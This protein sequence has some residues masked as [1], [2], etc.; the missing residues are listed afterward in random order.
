M[1]PKFRVAMID[2]DYPSLDRA[3]QELETFEALLDAR[4]CSTIDEAIAFARHADGVIVQ[5]LGPVDAVFMDP[6]EKCKVIARTGI[7][8]DPIDVPA[9]TE[10]GICVVH[11][12]GYCE[13]EVAD[14]T[15]ALLLAC[16]RKVPL[17]DQN[18]K[19]GT[20][21]FNVGA[22][23]HRLR[24]RTLGLIGFGKIS[25]MVA[26][27]AQGFG[28][29]VVVHDPYLDERQVEEFDVELV[30]FD[31]LL[32]RSDFVSL[33]APLNDTSRGM[34]NSGAL[35]KM[36]SDAFL[37]NTAR[38]PLVNES[39]LVEALRSGIIAGAAL[40]V[41]SEEPPSSKSELCELDNVI[42]T[43]HAAYYSVESLE[44]LQTLFARYTGMVLVGKR[45]EGLA[46][47]EVLEKVT[48]R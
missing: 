47:P 41:R 20:W 45:P 24:G 3:R 8:L 16:A 40:D 36:K 43:P 18:V 23:L 46:N 22:P 27:R 19:A 12:P 25:R 28:L 11:V 32:E 6:L 14:H 26:R 10:R 21:D 30:S 15:L 5:K 44:L 17:Y 39:D 29:R 13:E 38:G 2:Y 34:M 7:G 9:A 31:A 42:L 1:Q 4:N 35:G 37:I 33:H 48:L